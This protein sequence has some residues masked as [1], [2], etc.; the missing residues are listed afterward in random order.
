[1]SSGVCCS[2][3]PKVTEVS[4]LWHLCAVGLPMASPP[5]VP[6]PSRRMASA[7]PSGWLQVERARPIAMGPMDVCTAAEMSLGV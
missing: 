1:M 3:V 4:A 2:E 7:L 5:R 6:C